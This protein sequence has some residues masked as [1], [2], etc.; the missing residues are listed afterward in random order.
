MEQTRKGLMMA[1]HRFRLEARLRSCLQAILELERD[2]QQAGWKALMQNE[3]LQ[4]RHFLPRVEKLPLQEQEVQQVEQATCTL[5][6]ELKDM[7]AA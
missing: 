3:L 5:L 2:M 1:R 6:Q 4:L 7:Y